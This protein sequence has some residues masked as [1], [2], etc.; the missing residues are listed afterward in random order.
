M[1]VFSLFLALAFLPHYSIGQTPSLRLPNLVGEIDS[2]FFPFEN[3]ITVES[4]S[5]NR[6]GRAEI[7]QELDRLNTALHTD[8]IR[9]DSV[10]FIASVIQLS[11]IS[12]LLS[13]GE[14]SLVIEGRLANSAERIKKLGP[15]H[16][17]ELNSIL[18][19]WVYD[20]AP[21]YNCMPFYRDGLIFRNEEKE[22]VGYINICFDCRTITAYP[23][24]YF[25]LNGEQ[26][27]QL[28]QYFTEQLGHPV[29]DGR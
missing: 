5:F 25:S 14:K 3:Y 6:I 1:K 7:R 19:N 9:Y 20:G 8:S 23:K 17:T 24:F 22:I 12:Q 26:W 13:L 16:I 4:Y 2:S 15:A 29:E 27:N 18:S 28:H 21:G 11:E 10:K